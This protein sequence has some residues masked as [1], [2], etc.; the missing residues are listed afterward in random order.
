MD[1]AIQTGHCDPFTGRNRRIWSAHK[2]TR[3]GPRLAPP[4]SHDLVDLA[5][6]PASRRHR[7]SDASAYRL[8]SFVGL[9]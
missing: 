2:K 8:I 4:G 9:F 3:A 5:V 6:L 1:S 7:H